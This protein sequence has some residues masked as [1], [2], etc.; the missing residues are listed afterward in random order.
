MTA[1]LEWTEELYYQLQGYAETIAHSVR[2]TFPMVDVEDLVQEAMMWAVQHPSTLQGYLALESLTDTQR[3]VS[4]AMRNACRDYA[5]KQR[6]LQRGD[7]TLIDDAWYSLATLKGTGRVA[8]KRGLLHYVFDEESWTH[9]EKGDSEVR[10][11]RDPAEGNNWLATLADVSS[12]L[13][14][15]GRNDPAAH[16][17]IWLHYKQGYTYEE[18]GAGLEPAVSRET[19]SK[20]MDRAIKKVQELLGGPRPRK[21]P[22]EEGW[23]EGYVG[24][25]RAISNAHA[26]ALT[27]T[28]YEE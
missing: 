14:K 19:V 22:A 23:E 21:D 18:I 5:V 11:K 1:I 25:R 9:P 6:A 17:L 7:E 27:S 3:R 4:G 15:L 2:R 20:R 12:A 26:R 16:S 24:S 13:E 10:T 28:S 8:S